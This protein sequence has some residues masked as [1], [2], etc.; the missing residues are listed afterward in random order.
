MLGLEA[1]SA[2]NGW[3]MAI[4]GTCI[5]MSGLA[6]LAFI[7]SQLHRII[8]LFEKKAVVAAVHTEPPADIDILKDIG[9]A[10]RAY[11]LM[12][13]DLGESFQL[14]R[15][16]EAFEK[17]NLPHPHLTINALREAGYLL[18]LG[19]GVFSWKNE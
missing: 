14:A 12:T 7:I 18:P 3:S 5:V 17:K 16:Y 1:I 15:L 10:F 11:Q 2:N 4:I 19:G 9:G 13:A 6:G 8:R